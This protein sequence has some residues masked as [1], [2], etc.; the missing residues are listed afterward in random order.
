MYALLLSG[1]DAPRQKQLDALASRVAKGVLDETLKLRPDV[2]LMAARGKLPLVNLAL[3]ALRNLSPDQFD[4]FRTAIQVLIES[5]Q[6]IDWFEYVLQKIVRRHLEP[7][8]RGARRPVVQYYAIQPLLP[9]CVFLLSV[10]ACVGQEGPAPVAA[11]F[12]LGWRELGA[13]E[14]AGRLLPISDC[15]PAQLDA[16]LD[17]LAQASPLI[18][19]KVLNACAH[20]VAADGV[21]KE[22]EAELLRAV[23]DTLDCPIP[24]FV[25]GV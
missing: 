8:F 6:Q 2:S 14:S 16:I 12:R 18:K 1:D 15:R 7:H 3:P 4:Q 10:L 22:E 21:I 17:R 9:D 25:A 5:D 11:A 19:K 20:T 23:A 13:P 24:P